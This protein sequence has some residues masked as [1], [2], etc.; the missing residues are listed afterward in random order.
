MLG[1]I[2]GRRRREWQRMRWL[3]GI[4]NSTEMSLSKLQELV[5]DRETWCAAV[6]GVTELD[7]TEQLNWT[8]GKHIENG[9]IH[10][11]LRPHFTDLKKKLEPKLISFRYTPPVFLQILLL[12]EWLSLKPRAKSLCLQPPPS[13]SFTKSLSDLQA[14]FHSF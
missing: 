2:E 13:L 9:A 11:Q 12:I 14:S 8:D 7:R 3:D 5:M 1:K 4:T 10:Y 6:H